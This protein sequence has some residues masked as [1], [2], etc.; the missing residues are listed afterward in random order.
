VVFGVLGMAITAFCSTSAVE[1]EFGVDGFEDDE[2][3]DI[4]DDN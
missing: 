1:F 4:F 2:L 3:L